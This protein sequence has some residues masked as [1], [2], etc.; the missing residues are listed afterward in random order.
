MAVPTELGDIIE[1]LAVHEASL[2]LELNDLSAQAKRVGE[3]L[4]QIQSA[5]AALR[6]DR[7]K[8]TATSGSPA[9]RTKP[10]ANPTLVQEL[11]LAALGK[12][13]HLSFDQ[14]LRGVKSQMLARGLSRVGAKALLATLITKPPFTVNPDQTITAA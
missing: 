7:P 4:N 3:R 6:D 2:T 8:S 1:N 14:L 10:R 9:T 11:A 5:L 13:D 12:N